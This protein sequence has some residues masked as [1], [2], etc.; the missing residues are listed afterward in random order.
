VDSNECRFSAVGLYEPGR[1]LAITDPVVGSDV[2]V[3]GARLVVV[4]GANGGG[5]STVLRAAGLA[6]L[7]LGAGMFV[8]AERLTAS[9]RPGIR[10]HF[11][12]EEDAAME[13]GKLDEE[14]SRLREVVDGSSPGSLV[15]LNESQSST[16]EREGGGDRPAGRHRARG[17]GRLRL[18][19]DPTT[20]VSP[21]SCSVTVAPTSPSCAPGSAT[22]PNGR[23]GSRRVPPRL[24]ATAWTST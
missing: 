22:R 19:R 4:T 7:M 14:L 20:I 18:V 2:A 12:R 11:T 23:S 1:R 17:R 6:Q 16:I 3:D 24:P 15:L 13:G 5:K 9:I 21:S 10:T 8:G